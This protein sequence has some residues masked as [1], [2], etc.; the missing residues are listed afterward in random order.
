MIKL[1]IFYL[2]WLFTVQIWSPTE[3]TQLNVFLVNRSSVA[4]FTFLI[5]ISLTLI[6][7]YDNIIV[8]M[9]NNNNHRV[10]C[11]HRPR[12]WLSIYSINGVT[13][14]KCIRETVF[15]ETVCQMFSRYRWWINLFIID[16]L[17]GKYISSCNPDTE[18]FILDHDSIDLTW[19]A[20]RRTPRTFETDIA[21]GILETFK[22][23]THIECLLWIAINIAEMPLYFNKTYC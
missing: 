9:N 8:V 22:Q 11:M 19:S 16:S 2:Y 6:I 14:G 17:I 23:L 21:N 5:S 18:Y 10:F 4:I 20:S 3:N 1:H 12:W 15:G 7:L 13:F